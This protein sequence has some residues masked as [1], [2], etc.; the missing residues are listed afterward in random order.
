[1]SAGK[2]R[3]IGQLMR[4]LDERADDFVQCRQHYPVPA[5]Q[6]H[7]AVRK[8]VD[9]FGCACKM[10]ELCNSRHLGIS[11]QAIPEPVF[12]GLD[13]VVGAG[14]DELDRLRICFGKICREIVKLCNG[15]L[16]NGGTSAISGVSGSR[17]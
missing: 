15:S 14:F 5:V 9:V 11:C 3:H 12:D 13:V 7:Q 4:H 1:M 2:H 8:V 6:Q 17:P 16:E 10:D